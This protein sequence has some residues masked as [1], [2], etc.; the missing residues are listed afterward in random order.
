[1]EEGRRNKK[2]L[3]E[4]V[5]KNGNECMVEGM[6]GGL[7]HGSFVACMHCFSFFFAVAV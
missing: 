7:Y 2:I 1:M 3:G 4:G 6:G 5:E